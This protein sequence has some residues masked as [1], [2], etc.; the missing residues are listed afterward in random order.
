MRNKVLFNFVIASVAISIFKIGGFGAILGVLLGLSFDIV[1]EYA[2]KGLE[3][4][5]YPVFKDDRTLIA[6]ILL[7]LPGIFLSA[8]PG[9][10]FLCFFVFLLA[11]MVAN[12]TIQVLFDD[13]GSI[14]EE[15]LG[16]S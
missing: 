11:G 13:S 7:F 1:K 4:M 10:S 2:V 16:D 6:F 14:C 8:L 12:A 15:Q 9:V 5:G 3:A